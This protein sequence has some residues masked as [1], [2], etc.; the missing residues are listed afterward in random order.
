MAGILVTGGCGYVGSRLVR[1]LANSAPG[2]DV[3]ILDNLQRDSHRAL[4]DLP[5]GP[6][7]S[8][9]Q[10]DILDRA[11][12]RRALDGVETVIHLAG[13]VRTPMTFENP[14]WMRQVNHWGTQWL[15]EAAL[16]AGVKRF[17]YASS[18]AVYG[19]GGPH[20]EAQ[21]P[22]PVGPYAESKA[23]GE[24]SLWP[25]V[26]RGLDVRIVRLGMV[27][28]DAPAMRLDGVVNRLVFQAATGRPVTVYG[29]GE[30]RRPV[31]HV[32][33]AAEALLHVV[34]MGSEASGS[35]DRGATSEPLR[36]NAVAGN[37]TIN[38]LAQGIAAA[39][40]RSRVV[41]VDQDVE[42]HLSFEVSGAALRYS[43]WRPEV[44]HD[45][46]IRALLARFGRL[47]G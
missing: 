24:S 38:D 30:Q 4:M 44:D 37:P 42:T 19:P 28:G 39:S 11:L 13:I 9:V 7:Y 46:A 14:T 2:A 31:I 25:F 20:T 27:Y 22:R 40:P 43:G 41:F 18:T 47:S 16:S 3:R 45:E 33:D 6:R 17:V 36:L 5:A 15:A 34:S 26:S 12:L 29:S 35:Q 10:G 21:L 8:F 1:R 32:D 23:A